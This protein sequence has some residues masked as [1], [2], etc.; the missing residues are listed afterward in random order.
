MIKLKEDYL[1]INDIGYIAK[2]IDKK[3]PL[4]QRMKIKKS[5]ALKMLTALVFYFI[6]MMFFSVAL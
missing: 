4:F 2:L 6:V 1:E 3:M 5:T